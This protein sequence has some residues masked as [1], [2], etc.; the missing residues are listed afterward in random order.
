MSLKTLFN[1]ESPVVR[2]LEIV[3]VILG[4]VHLWKNLLPFDWRGGIFLFLLACCLFIFACDIIDWYPEDQKPA[5]SK[6]KIGIEVHFLKAR[7]PTSYILAITAAIAL[8]RIP[9][10]STTAVILAVVMM[11]VIAPVNGI[12]LW[13]HRKD[14]DA[15]PMNYFSL[16]KYLRS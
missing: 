10:V 15:T 6:Q 13:F 14:K 9:Y 4:A 2:S 16:N 11:L 5:G 8:L 7:V 1:R 12:L 3:G